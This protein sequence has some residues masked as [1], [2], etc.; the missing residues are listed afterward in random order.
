MGRANSVLSLQTEYKLGKGGFDP[1]KPFTK[2]C[3][4][5]GFVAWAIGIPRELP[6]NSGKWLSTD[7]YWAGGKP[8]KPGLLTQKQLKDAQIGDILVYPDKGGGQG[9]ISIITQVDHNMPSLIIHCSSGNFKHFNNAVRITDPSVFLS[10][11]H[12]TRILSI[13]YDVLRAIKV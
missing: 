1:T 12:D 5:T 8:T 6:P 4:C 9:H 11:N 2:Q 3:D 7:E 13:N 10:G